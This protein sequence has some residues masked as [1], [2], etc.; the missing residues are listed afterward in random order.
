MKILETLLAEDKGASTKSFTLVISAIAS[1]II[2]LCLCFAIIW[3]VI[4]NGY[5]KSNLEDLGM[6]ILCLGGY[7]GSSSVS[8][9]FQEKYRKDKR[10]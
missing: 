8:K 7:V 1:G 2:C 5:I 6:F 10:V 3:D 4:T 9:I